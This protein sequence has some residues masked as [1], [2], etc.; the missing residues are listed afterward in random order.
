MYMSCP[1]VMIASRIMSALDTKH[2][3]PHLIST[4]NSTLGRF[5]L[6]A[7]QTLF[8]TWKQCVPTQCI[9]CQLQSVRLNKCQKLQRAN[10]EK[11][12]L[13]CLKEKYSKHL[14][15]ID[16]FEATHHNAGMKPCAVTRNAFGDRSMSS[17][18][19]RFACTWAWGNLGLTRTF[20]LR[21]TVDYTSQ[22]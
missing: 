13:K 4:L 16:L 17:C 11:K 7:L 14:T 9:R 19:F 5:F 15:N 20:R 2:W 21:N 3:I 12:S 8:T 6:A 1:W 22:A 10:K 18:T